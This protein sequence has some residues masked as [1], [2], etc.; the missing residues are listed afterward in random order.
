MAQPKIAV[1]IS[2]SD[3]CLSRLSSS[4]DV[5]T[6]PNGLGGGSPDI[7]LDDI[8]A[9]VTNGSTGLSDA[10][11]ARLP[12]LKLA[13]AYGAGYENVDIEAAKRRGVHVTHAPNTNMETV[14]DHAM[15]LMLAVARDI[16]VRDRA[17]RQ[18]AWGAIRSAR[19][20]L[21]RARLGIIGLGNIGKAIAKRGEAFG[22]SIAYTTR[23][24]VAE[25]PWQ[26][27]AD[28][29]S[30]ARDS[31]FLIVACPGGPATRHLVGKAVLDALGPEG[32]AINV[33][34]GMVVDT[35]ALVVALKQN[36]I[37]GAGLDVFEG[38]PNLPEGLRDLDNVVLTPHMAGRSPTSE[39]AQIDVLLHNLR[40]CHEG[41]PLTAQLA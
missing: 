30:L 28:A 26:H 31:D 37:A 8:W 38:E 27:H 24:K 10:E 20:T 17:L 19:P 29:V 21:S 18:G 3:N 41:R 32:F 13:C 12:K 14:A 15:A 9:V 23:N 11:M 34:R 5:I 2:V 39:E 36:T 4:Y 40:A 33:S 16:C 6:L 1:T 35:E 7:A 25:V 22:M